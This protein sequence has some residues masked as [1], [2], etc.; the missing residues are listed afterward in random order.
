MNIDCIKIHLLVKMHSNPNL[1]YGL[2]GLRSLFHPAT[3][4]S[5]AIL[6]LIDEKR[7]I[8]KESRIS[9]PT[10]SLTN[11]EKS[12]KDAVDPMVR[13]LAKEMKEEIIIGNKVI[14]GKNTHKSAI[15]SE[16]EGKIYGKGINVITPDKEK[17]L[18]HNMAKFCRDNNL[19][20]SAMYKTS[21]GR[22]P[23][24]EGYQVVHAS[25]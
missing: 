20:L 18:V 8:V 5:N 22:Q 15:P 24:H 14:L 2:S 19:S 11:K 9:I 12:R 6:E 4:F 13:R 17:I 21:K 16:L 7:I 10:V 1:E 25:S 3:L 23:H